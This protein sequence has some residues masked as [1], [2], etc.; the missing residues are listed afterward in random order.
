MVI[1]YIVS[2]VFTTTSLYTRLT[3]INFSHTIYCIK[4]YRE[5]KVV[6]KFGHVEFS[7]DISMLNLIS[8]LYFSHSMV[9]RKESGREKSIMILN[10]NIYVE[11]LW[12]ENVG[13]I[14]VSLRW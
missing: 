10:R 11:I 4:W 13:S 12:A 9:K 5:N 7:T 2:T 6:M 14:N 3:T 8:Q 1:S